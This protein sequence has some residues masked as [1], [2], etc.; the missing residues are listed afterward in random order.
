MKMRQR[1]RLSVVAGL[2]VMTIAGSAW[3]QINR[4]ILEGSV[5][6]PQGAAIPSVRVEVTAVSTNVT[7]PTLTNS[8]GYYRVTDLV[9]GGYKIHFEVR[10]FSPLELTG[11]TVTPGQSSRADAQLQLG[12][13]TQA[14]TVSAAVTSIQ[15]ASTNFSTTVGTTTI[16]SLPIQGRDIQ[17][18]I[19]QVP[20]II[21]NGPPGSSFGFN[22][23]FGTFPDPTHL[24][25]TD[26][27]VNGGQGGLNAWYLDGNLNQSA[28][29]A[30]TVVVN[31][32]PDAV[33]EFQ[34]ITSGLSAEYGRSGGGV[35][36]I[37][38]KS[39]TNKVHGNAYEYL[40]NSYFNA[41]NPFTSIDSQG[42]IVPQDQLRYNDFGGTLGGPV[43]IPHLYDGR[44]KTFFFF[45]WDESILHLGGNGV[46]TVP[47]P[48]M[49]LGNF[50]EDPNTAKFG[51]W[52][53][54]STA[55]PD[56]QGLFQRT[57][58]GSPAA[59]FPSGCLNTVVE[60]N[61]GV[62]TCN[63]S[64]QIPANMMSNTAAFFMKAFPAPNY[65]D[66]LSGC[67]LANGGAYRICNNYLGSIGSIQ[68]N[69]NISLKIDHNWSDKSRYFG[70]WLFSP[71]NYNNSRLPWTGATFPEGSIGYGSNVP[72]D[73][74][75]QIISFGNT[76]T[77]NP[78]LINEFRASFS[79]QY[80]TTHPETGGY[81]DSVTG[82]SSV[83]QLL[84]PLGI[85]EYPPTP[86]PSW[87]VNTPG[88]GSMN[89]G[90]EAWV[91][92][93]TASESY[94]I[95]DNVTKILGKHTL[96]T[97]F[98]YRLSHVAEFQ[99]APDDLGF[100]GAGNVDPTTGLGGGSG[101][102]ELLMGA[103]MSTS[104]GPNASWQPYVRFRYWGFYGQDDYHV[105][106]HLTLSL[107]LRYD[108]F[109]SFKARQPVSF[110]CLS[111]PN[112]ATGLPGTL[113][114]ANRD[115]V[116]PNW[117]DWAPR[118]N[119][120]W[121]PGNSTRTVV[122][123]GYD[124]FFSNAYSSIN[125]PQTIENLSG[126][127]SDDIWEGSVNPAQCQALASQCVSWSLDS[128]GPKG[129]LSTPA[130]SLTLPAATKNPEY[131]GGLGAQQKPAHDP[132]VQ[133]W[134]L[135]VQRALPGDVVLSVGYVGS[136]GTHTVGGY[137][138]EYDYVHTA[139]VLQYR[140]S[141]NA[142][143]PIA[144]YYSGS[145]AQALQQV[146]G[147]ATLPLSQLLKPYPF[148]SSLNGKQVF[149][150]NNVYHSL[151]LRIEKRFSHGLNFNTAYTVSKNIG[152]AL[153]GQIINMVID[154]IHLGPRNGYVGGITGAF[155][156]AARGYRQ[157]QDPDN[158]AADRSLV[159]N[160]M[161]Q[162]LS[163]SSTYQLP[164]GMGKNYLNR[165]GPL[166]L[167]VGGWQLTGSFVAESGV[168]LS[169]SGPCNAV[170]CRPDL[171]GNPR[172]VSGGQNATSWINSAAFLPPFGS[173]QSFWSN[174]NTSDNRWWQ[175]GT[176][177][178]RLPGLRSPG[179]WNL[180]ASLGKQFYIDENRYFDFRWEVFNALNHQ[181]L[182]VP[183][184]TYCL[185]A[186]PDGSTDLVHQAGCQ[187][188]RI[189]NV[190]TD[191]RSM[192]FALKFNW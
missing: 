55:G 160:D 91:S 106:P 119:F 191:P 48:A 14:I 86:A 132:M 154:P 3:A 83:Q 159:F 153:D 113:T 76:Y 71:G 123:G 156:N 180:D 73:F 124:V 2:V 72:F 130:F 147:S 108:I 79:R 129:P 136:H 117:N 171:V 38:L 64:T 59:G 24:Q 105:T 35:F 9:P 178:A 110:F 57:A 78:N 111:C 84:A 90:P 188:G 183:N 66:P 112:S 15:T 5:T 96:R 115:Y 109:G 30:E 8:A 114:Y 53:P 192:E 16:A 187:F 157:Y 184:T 4:G 97:G 21:G 62:T 141:I 98:V 138:W 140:N 127:S 69:A 107:G 42:H 70:E 131:T 134:S 103:V 50:S 82:L 128:P 88:G 19:F 67:P 52:N 143:L 104:S 100:Y 95:L 145:T 137:N 44:N 185:S 49:R 80:Y 135:E 133:T 26:V 75:N 122:R 41:R 102:A 165:R 167:L 34:A 120:S 148:W 189:T 174:P 164:L 150:G 144:D 56:S 186:L 94:T 32:S 116:P 182:G 118:V 51:L 161:P 36:N 6:D 58:F 63:F 29:L 18:Y 85:P 169:I 11:V 31:P 152:S 126:Y 45:S 40:R 39:G 28:G 87:F 81:P 47:T 158:I 99:S 22:S 77:L 74:A 162:I 65:L 61:P 177:G 23:Q 27:S 37:V 181:S 43:V 12:G 89:W 149:D 17:Q 101:L 175:F 139:D 68:N 46:F 92:N 93:M 25:G 170:T 7:L 142:Q 121:S 155:R 163:V 168:P 173:D 176:A 125:S 13:T 54:Y 172:A 10:G 60:A 190:Q 151:D 1:A 20:G 166:N 179:Y 146:W 33:E